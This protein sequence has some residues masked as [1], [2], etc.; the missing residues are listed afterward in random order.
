MTGD[1][2]LLPGNPE[3]GILRYKDRYYSFVSKAA[4]E[5]FASDPD[6]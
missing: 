2:L 6:S 4:A 1:R 5:A 3:I